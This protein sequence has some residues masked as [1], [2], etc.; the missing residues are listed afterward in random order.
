MPRACSHK[1]GESQAEYT[2]EINYLIILKEG[3]RALPG[4]KGYWL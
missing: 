3:S 1:W 2:S 4:F